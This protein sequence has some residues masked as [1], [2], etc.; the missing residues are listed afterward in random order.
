MAHVYQEAQ[1]WYA[2]VNA[3]VVRR[4]CKSTQLPWYVVLYGW[5]AQRFEPVNE[6]PISRKDSVK[7]IILDSEQTDINQSKIS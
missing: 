5:L 6:H 7:K 4:Y 2:D 3:R 1:L